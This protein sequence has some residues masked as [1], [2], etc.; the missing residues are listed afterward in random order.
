MKQRFVGAATS[1]STNPIWVINTR[2]TVKKSSMEEGSSAKPA[3]SSFFATAKA[4][5]KEEGFQ[6]FFRGIIPALILVVNPIIQYTVFEQLKAK[7]S[8]TKAALTS[9]DFFLL[10]AISKLAATG[11]TYPY[12]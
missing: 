2:Q 6:G 9:L 4:I 8:E 3:P 1:L 11:S 5:I 7:L 12:M 10:G